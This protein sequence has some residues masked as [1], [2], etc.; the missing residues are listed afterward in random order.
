MRKPHYRLLLCLL[1]LCGGLMCA[2]AE[3]DGFDVCAEPS[4]AAM[5]ALPEVLSEAGLFSDMTTEALEERVWAYE[6]RF[7]L[8]SDGATKRRWVSIPAGET[9][10][11]SDMDQ[12]RF[13]VGTKLFK[14]FTRDGVRVETRILLKT[15]QEDEDWSASAYVWSEDQGDALLTPEGGVN[16]LG[17]QH[18][19]PS[20]AKCTGCHG[21]RASRVLG[22]SAVQ[23]AWSP[24]VGHAT[25][26]DLKVAGVLS[27]DVPEEIVLPG[28]SLDQEALGYLHANCS[29]CHNT[30][31]PATGGPRCYDPEESFDFSFPAAGVGSVQESPAYSTGVDERVLVRGDADGSRLVQ[32]LSTGNPRMPALGSEDIDEE[33]RALL[34]SWVDSL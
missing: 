7:E 19:V 3:E 14:E 31:R 20:A 23:L 17:T 2:C 27:E 15:G 11:T 24:P 22:F 6:P 18:D 25:V 21:G 29:H 30:T 13:P 5:A 28:A 26:A 16:Q 8:W 12:W 10:D 34:T 9:V 32:R 4:E 1:V 33:G